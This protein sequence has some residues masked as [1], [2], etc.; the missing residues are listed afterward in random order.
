[1]SNQTSAKAIA[2]AAAAADDT[3]DVDSLDGDL[4]RG[5]KRIAKFN[6]GLRQERRREALIR[7]SASPARF[8]GRAWRP[9]TRFQVEA[10]GT[11]Q[12]PIGYRPPRSWRSPPPPPSPKPKTPQPRPSARRDS[13]ANRNGDRAMPSGANSTSR[14]NER[15][16]ERREPRPAAPNLSRDEGA[17]SRTTSAW[18]ALVTCRYP[19][20]PKNNSLSGADLSCEASAQLAEHATEI[21]R[22]GN[23]VTEDI[24]AIGE[25]LIAAK[26]LAGHGHWHSWLEREF[27][28]KDRTAQRYMTV[29]RALTSNPSGLTDLDTSLEALYR[30]ASPKTPPEVIQD[31]AALGRKITIRRRP[32]DVRTQGPPGQRP[33]PASDQYRS[34]P[35]DTPASSSVQAQVR[36][37][38]AERRSN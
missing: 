5:G 8:S 7:R 22:L 37:G 34:P 38:V 2:A 4:L 27:G 12:G 20:T 31:V 17:A 1:M 9:L 14:G 23:R 29:A 11:L 32:G 21:R 25:H 26:K 28:W 18:E 10:A 15:S 33:D 6:Y 3:D 35:C 16:P 36:G 24:V 30:L 13:R 19:H